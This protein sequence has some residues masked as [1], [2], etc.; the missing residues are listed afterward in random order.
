LTDELEDLSA[1]DK[2]ALKG[3]IV[4]L[5][6]DSPRTELAGRRT[7]GAKKEPPL[8]VPKQT[9]LFSLG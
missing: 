3:T 7:I 8:S 9:P 4:D 2:I 6:T 1:D 5:T